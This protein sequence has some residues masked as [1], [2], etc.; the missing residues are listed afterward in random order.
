M[1]KCDKDVLSFKYEDITQVFLFAPQNVTE[2][3]VDFVYLH[4]ILSHNI[5]ILCRIRHNICIEIIYINDK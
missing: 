4:R 1:F 5:K 2:R 3:E